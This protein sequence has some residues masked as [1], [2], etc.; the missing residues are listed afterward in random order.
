M[1]RA[2]WCTQL[3]EMFQAGEHK[4]LIEAL[5]PEIRGTVMRIRGL[6]PEQRDDLMSETAVYL[7]EEWARGKTYGKTPIVAVARARAKYL[8]RDLFQELDEPRRRGFKVVPLDYAF[9]T[10]DGDGGEEGPEI[11]PADPGPGPEEVYLEQDLMYRAL[12]Q[13]PP[14]DREVFRLRCFEGLGSYEVAECLDCEPN[15]V[16][17][18]YHRAK[19]RLR[20]DGLDL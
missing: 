10:H 7:L 12:D 17:Q 8:A 9:P 6:T 5:R 14:R 15:A 3:D 4:A 19:R 18:A 2:A 1:S 16:D 13:L 20:D 11:E